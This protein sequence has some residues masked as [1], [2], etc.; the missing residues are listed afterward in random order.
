MTP[1]EKN[2]FKALAAVAWADGTVSE[3]ETA[4]ID[5]LLW[6]FGATDEE[7]AELRNYAKVRRSIKDIEASKLSG[8]EKELMIAHAALLTHADGQQT[9]DEQQVL[10]ALVKHLGFSLDQAKPL[11]AGAKERASKLAARL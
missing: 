10:A 5:S 11:I 2:M 1:S 8:E 9:K 6:A 7:E 3:P 4:M